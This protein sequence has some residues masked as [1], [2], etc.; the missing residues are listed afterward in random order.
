MLF[1]IEQSILAEETLANLWSF[2]KS[3]S[4]KVFLHTVCDL[5]IG[6]SQLTFITCILILS[7]LSQIDRRTNKVPYK[8]TYSQNYH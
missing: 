6:T 2:A 3:A 8:E 4:S 1:S 7:F 5:C